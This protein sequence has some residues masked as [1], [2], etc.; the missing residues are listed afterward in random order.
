MASLLSAATNWKHRNVSVCGRVFY[1][2]VSR[3]CLDSI[4]KQT[5]E[6]PEFHSGKRWTMSTSEVT[7]PRLKTISC[8]NLIMKAKIA[9]GSVS[10]LPFVQQMCRISEQFA[11]AVGFSVRCPQS[12]RTDQAVTEEYRENASNIILP[13]QKLPN[14]PGWEPVRTRARGLFGPG[15]CGPS[16]C[17]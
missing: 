1:K 5:C 6:G 15:G 10:C 8:L 12:Q 11:A 9:V 7:Y 4:R 3:C 16:P 2:S 17:F 14:I 13:T